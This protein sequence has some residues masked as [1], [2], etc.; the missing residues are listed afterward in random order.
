MDNQKLTATQRENLAIEIIKYLV[1]RDLFYDICIYINNQRWST[2]KKD[3]A[4]EK[5]IS[6]KTTVYVE[7][8]I[9]VLDYIVYGNPETITV[10]FEG[11]LYHEI[12]YGSAKAVT[13]INKILDK[14]GMYLE[15]GYAWTFAA[16]F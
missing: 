15:Q 7:N 8:N 13:D 10:S 5:R 1:K 12:N 11:P 9:D 16:Y 6:D 4:T 14:Y 3:N 2:N